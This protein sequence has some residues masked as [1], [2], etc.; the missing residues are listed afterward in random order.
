[1]RRRRSFLGLDSKEGH[2]E[3]VSKVDAEIEYDMKEGIKRQAQN[4]A[5]KLSKHEGF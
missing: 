3:G 1:M 4:A 2:T 5:Y